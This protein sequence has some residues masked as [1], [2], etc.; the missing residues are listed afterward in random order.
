MAEPGDLAGLAVGASSDHHGPVPPRASRGGRPTPRPDAPD[1]A[2]SADRF[3]A[4]VRELLRSP[5]S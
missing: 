5:A 3:F 1:V 4:A 2:A